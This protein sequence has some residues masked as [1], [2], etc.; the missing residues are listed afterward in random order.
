MRKTTIKTSLVGVEDHYDERVKADVIAAL[1]AA[2]YPSKPGALAKVSRA[3]DVDY[4]LVRAWYAKYEEG[5]GGTVVEATVEKT[6]GDL[7]DFLVEELHEITATLITTRSGATY[8]DLTSAFGTLFDR[9]SQL[10]ALPK[11]L[12]DLAPEL[13]ELYAL[14]RD[15]DIDV[16]IIIRS[17]ISKLRKK[18]QERDDIVVLSSPE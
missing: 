13:T 7:R 6:K 11:E 17:M 3:F 5:R 15:L 2:G 10:D 18:V 14:S 8:R 4:R 12:M 16:R 1:V 9:L